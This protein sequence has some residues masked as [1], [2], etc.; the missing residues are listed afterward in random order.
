MCIYCNVLIFNK[1]LLYIFN[2][3]LKSA[4]GFMCIYT[5]GWLFLI[6]C[7]YMLKECKKTNNYIFIWMVPFFRV[8]K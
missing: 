5:N 7:D 6:N 3:C 4:K 1:L 2:L 8:K